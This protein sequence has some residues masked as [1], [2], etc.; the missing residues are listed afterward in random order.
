MENHWPSV[1]GSP[2]LGQTT[3]LSDNKKKGGENKTNSGLCRFQLKLKLNKKRYEYLVLAREQK[4]LW[5]MKM[6]VI[7]IVFGALGTVTKRLIQRLDD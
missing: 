2:N 7:P 4:K 3:R 1:N 5:N 6:T